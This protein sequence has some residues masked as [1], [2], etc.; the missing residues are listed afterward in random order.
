V[1][2]KDGEWLKKV[3]G[4]TITLLTKATPK[5]IQTSDGVYML[6]LYI[7]KKEIPEKLLNI[8]LQDFIFLQFQH[9]GEKISFVRG[10]FEAEGQLYVTRKRKWDVRIIIH[11]KV[12]KRLEKV[13]EILDELTIPSK[14]YGPYKNGKSY[15]FRLIIF[16][17]TQAKK[18]WEI[19]NP[20]S[21]MIKFKE[22]VKF[23]FGMST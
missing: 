2:Q 16:T 3:V 7:K 11:Q 6:W 14:I 19:I 17:K 22:K 21:E 1:R 15:I 20:H 8:L 18:F 5:I 9:K 23:A 10:F 12:R 4:K 13:K